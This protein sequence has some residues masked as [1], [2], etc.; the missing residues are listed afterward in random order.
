MKERRNITPSSEATEDMLKKLY[1]STKQ[2]KEEVHLKMK[3]K[4][5]K[6]IR[7]KVYLLHML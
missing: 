7:E 6:K 1:S 3:K 5:R 4:K 2:D